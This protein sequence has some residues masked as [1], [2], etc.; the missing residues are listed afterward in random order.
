VSVFG[1]V[2]RRRAL[3]IISRRH[4]SAIFA[5]QSPMKLPF[6]TQLS[7]RISLRAS[8]PRALDRDYQRPALPLLTRHPISISSRRYWTMNQFPIDYAFQPRL[9]G[10]LTLGRLPLPR[11][12]RAFGERVSHPSFRYSC[13]HTPF[14]PLQETS[15]S[16]FIRCQNAPLPRT[17]NRLSVHPRLRYLASAPLDLQRITTR[18]VSC[19]ALFQGMAASKPTSW[20]SLQ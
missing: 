6:S 14:C 18:P 2:P 17:P 3:G 1:T 5:S 20:M 13:R 4:E 7:T 11:K 15:R 12:P 8:S 19:Y 10:R 16:P 9:R